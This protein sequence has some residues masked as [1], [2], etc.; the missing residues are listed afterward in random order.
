MSFILWL[1]FFQKGIFRSAALYI[2]HGRS[3]HN[4]ES[5][6]RTHNNILED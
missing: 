3:L 2:K 1:L 4:K 6:E 5:F